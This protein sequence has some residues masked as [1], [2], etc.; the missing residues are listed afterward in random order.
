MSIKSI[1]LNLYHKSN[2]RK[3]ITKA[4]IVIKMLKLLL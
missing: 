4:I 1:L 2:F 3:K